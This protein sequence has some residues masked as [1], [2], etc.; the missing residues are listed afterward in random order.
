MCEHT[1]LFDF[2]V[3]YMDHSAYYSL[4]SFCLG[5]NIPQEPKKIEK[6]GWPREVYHHLCVCAFFFL[7]FP[8]SMSIAYKFVQFNRIR[9]YCCCVFDLVYL[10]MFSISFLIP[11]VCVRSFDY[12]WTI[13]IICPFKLQTKDVFFFVKRPFN[14]F[15]SAS[16]FS[17]V[18]AIMLCVTVNLTL[19]FYSHVCAHA[20]HIHWL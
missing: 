3:P 16:S 9:W 8:P 18:R 5:T 12:S 4:Q 17:I 6:S 20:Q 2:S 13:V 19:F 14:F 15:S 10:C 1:D 7:A 11:T